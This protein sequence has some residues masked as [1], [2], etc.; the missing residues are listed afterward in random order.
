MPDAR[1]RE[2]VLRLQVQVEHGRMGVPAARVG[3][4]DSDVG[5]EGALVRREPGIAVYPEER[6]ACWA[7]VGDEVGAEP[8]QVRPEAADERQCRVADEIFL[9]SLV[10]GEPVAV[11]VAF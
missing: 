9:S 10:P 7:W 2:A 5:L 6:A 11:V 3:E 4:M 1:R 8:V